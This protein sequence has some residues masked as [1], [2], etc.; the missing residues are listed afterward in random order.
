ME[1]LGRLAKLESS[2]GG[3]Q[4]L[5]KECCLKVR[6][7]EADIEITRKEVED[8]IEV[9]VELKQRFGQMTDHLIQ[10]QA[11]V[12][13]LSSEKASLL[14]RIEAASRMVDENMSASDTADLASASSKGLESGTWGLSNSK[15]KPL[16]KDRIHSGRK[17]L[18]S[19]FQQLDSI[20]SAGA[21][22]L[23]RNPM[24]KLW[25]LVY[26]I[27]LRFWVVYIL[28]SGSQASNEARSGAL[29]SL[30]NINNTSGL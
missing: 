24:A 21:V 23:K 28:M 18:G 29:V 19:L 4:I 30:Q 16:L 26:L 8:P 11:Q 7:L 10:K 13:S 17:H 9:E 2:E 5:I 20:F 6:K 1:A 3:H 12:E 15:L 25:S 27:C 22:F 14:F